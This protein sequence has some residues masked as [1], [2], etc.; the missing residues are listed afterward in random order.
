MNDLLPDG[1][2]PL[3]YAVLVPFAAVFVVGVHRLWRRLGGIDLVA[4]LTK[5]DG[6]S[7]TDP[8][9]HRRLP[10]DIAARL[11]RLLDYGI[12]QR[13][14]VRRRYAGSMHLLLFWGFVVLFLGDLFLLADRYLVRP[15]G[16]RLLEGRIDFAFQAALDVAGVAFVAGV[17]LV[18]FR[19]LAWRPPGFS[20]GGEAVA[21]ALGLLFIGISGFVI[22]ALRLVLQPDPEATGAFVGRALAGVLG[23]A[24]GDA[25]LATYR[26]VWWAH[27]IAAFAFIAA[28]PFTRLAHMIASPIHVVMAATTPPGALPKPFDLR[29]LMETGNF[30]VTVGAATIEDLEPRDRLSLIACTECARCE[31]GC[32]AHTTGTRLSPLRMLGRM[33]G[34]LRAGGN[35]TAGEFFDDAVAPQE[36]WAC[37]MCG[38][39]A[40]QCPVL[41]RPSE[42]VA[43]LRRALVARGQ[44][45]SNATAMLDNL[46]RTGNPY[47]LPRLDRE[48]LARDLGVKTLKEMPD[49]EWLYWIGCAATYDPRVRAVAKATVRVL[50]AADVSFAILGGEETCT[51]DPARRLG[52]E[53]KFQEMALQNLETL[54]RHGVRRILTHCAH[55][56]NTFKNE[57]TDLGG[58][59]EVAHHAAFIRGLIAG[60]RFR[61]ARPIAETVTLHD[62]CYLGRLNGETRAPREVL[63]AI[64]GVRALEM[65]RNRDESFCCGAGGARYWYDSEVV[66]ETR[67]NLTRIDEARSTGARVLVSECPYC[68]KMFEDGVASE[69]LE[70]DLRVRDLA[71][72]VAET[73]D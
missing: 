59:F 60:G 35:G 31:E 50:Q 62:A 36:V 33:R 53:G 10:R 15:L 4:T 69:G 66:S 73:I 22:E 1:T 21:I 44:A 68:L 27:A 67:M 42:L 63:D 37:T 29:E 51:G 47:G 70:N 34:L 65:G 40:Q 39:C 6:R 61:P 30:D 38:T 54:D 41:I 55:C 71:E 72:L 28:L 52:E 58:R 17:L 56:F 46:A 7:G 14:V 13:R 25:A 23:A 20:T 5:P 24:S 43:Q 57:Y 64:G 2:A 49:A 45:G 48:E 8:L 18:L 26:V 32:P 12:L 16:G 11:R 19:R 3:M 9:R